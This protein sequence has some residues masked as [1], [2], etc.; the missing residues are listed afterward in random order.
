MIAQ[1]TIDDALT[2]PALLGAALGDIKTIKTWQTWR[3]VLK[4]AFG[5][6]LNREEARAFASVAGSRAPPTK[7]VRE[8]WAIVGRRGGKSRMAAALAVYIACFQQHRLANGEVGM[9]LCLAASQDQAKI[10]FK[11]VLA[12]LESSPILRQ[13]VVNVT[14]S[15]ITLRNGIVIA[16]HSNSFRT[17]RGRTLIACIFDEI[18][19]W[20]DEAS[21]MPDVETYRAI[22]PSLAT[23]N[24]MLIG[25]STPYRK[26]GL[27]HQKYKDFFGVD[28][29]E[30]L[31]VQGSTKQFNPSLS[32]RVIETQRAADP[33]AGASEWD[34][35]FRNDIASLFDDQLIDAAV[36]YGRP[37]ELPPTK[38]LFGSVYKAFT[39]PSGGVGQD[40]Y[41]L[42][43]AH[44]DGEQ[45]VLDL[46][47]GTQGK[48]D[49]QE[50]TRQ[51]AA[52]LREYG[53]HSVTGDHYAAEWTAGAWSSAGISYVPSALPKSQLYLECVPLFTRRLVRLPEHPTLLRELRLLERQTHRGGRDSVDH[54]RGQHDDHANS[55]CGALQ[56]LSDHL[57]Y[58]TDYAWVDGMPIGG[59]DNL[60][61]EERAARRREEA[62][63]WHR[64]R[65]MSYLGA[66]GAFGAPFGRIG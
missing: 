48:F 62:E 60:T 22:L 51:Y 5:T 53:V 47:R 14:R 15:E 27:L 17:I 50:V 61:N 42:A 4:A 64:T 52:L 12:F 43:I 39:D 35:V 21:A 59:T 32:D 44:K 10:V 26:L 40:A 37:L 30:V 6:T 57:G 18:A 63:A 65:L 54:P 7:R 1:H 58:R 66:H 46:V 29:D 20:R 13:E 2:D 11:Y 16:V 9:V 8:L 3:V 55:L 38:T 23:T 33:T 41:T 25:I 19:Y 49:P 24:G 36:E 45:F 28:D 56:Q 34:A 31:V